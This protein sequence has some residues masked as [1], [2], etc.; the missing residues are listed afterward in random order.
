[1]LAEMLW[2]RRLWTVSWLDEPRDRRV[3]RDH[4]R[5]RSEPG[6]NDFT[7]YLVKENAWQSE[8]LEDLKNFVCFRTAAY[9]RTGKL[10]LPVPT[11]I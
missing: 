8:W 10:N 6:T 7:D 4:L 11:I 3:V 1:V 5:L 9:H 2:S